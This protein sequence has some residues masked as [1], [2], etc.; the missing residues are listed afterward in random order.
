[1]APRFSLLRIATVAIT[2]SSQSD[3][4][5]VSR[6]LGESRKAACSGYEE[7]WGLCNT[8]K[9]PHECKPSP[10]KWS[11]WSQW[12]GMGMCTGLCS[13]ER[14]IQQVNNDCGTPCEG[15][16]FQTKECGGENVCILPKAVDC[17]YSHWTQWSHCDNMADQSYSER[18]FYQHPKYG[19]NACT[20]DVKRTKPCSKHS[21]TT[22]AAD[23]VLSQWTVWSACSRTCNTGHQVRTRRVVQETMWGGKGCDGSISQTQECGTS[24]C[25]GDIDCKL[26]DWTEWS[27]CESATKTGSFQRYRTR[28]VNQPAV[29]DG[30]PCAGAV[31]GIEECE[32]AKVA[33]KCVFDK[34]QAWGSCSAT[35]GGGQKYRNRHFKT[36]ASGGGS[37]PLTTMQETN[38]C[39]T[40]PC[41]KS[42]KYDDWSKWSECSAKCG[43]GQQTRERKVKDGHECEGAV[44]EVK[45]CISKHGCDVKDCRWGLWEPWSAC[46]LTCGGGT[47][48]RDR[49]VKQS[50]THGG[51]ECKAVP[52]R[53]IAPCNSKS[54]GPDCRDGTWS[55]W[56]SWS[57]CSA[58]CE[59]GFQSRQRLIASAP[60]YCGKPA[61]GL[62]VEMKKCSNNAKCAPS[63]DCELGKWSSWGS[64][65]QDCFGVRERTRRVV[66][67]A[68]GFFGKPCTN[69]SLKD[70]QG[71]NPADGEKTP[72]HC[73]LGP[74]PVDCKMSDWGAWSDCSK[75]CGPGQKTRVRSI[76]TYPESNGKPCNA[77]LKFTTSCQLKACEGPKC[78]DCKWGNWGEWGDC[79][80]QCDG[81]RE[82][83]RSIAVLPDWCGKNCS[84]SPAVETQPCKGVCLA[85]VFC[86]WSGWSTKSS[87]SDK[88]GPQTSSKSRSLKIVPKLP[89][90][91]PLS[92]GTKL[93]TCHG[94]DR[95][96][97]VCPFKSCDG[98][99]ED[100]EF[101]DWDEWSPPTCT[102][103]CE[104]SRTVKKNAKNGGKPCTG[105][106]VATKVCK[107]DCEKPVDC[108]ISGWASWSKC[109]A[110]NDQ[111]YRT[112]SIK[113]IA[114]FGGDRCNGELK[115]TKWCAPTK[116]PVDCE[117]GEWA[118][119]QTCTAS[120]GGGSRK[121]Q[122]SIKTNAIHGGKPCKD[123]LEQL[124]PC[125]AAAA[126]KDKKPKKPVACRLSTWSPWKNDAA[127]GQKKR[128][129]AIKTNRSDGGDMCSGNLHEVEPMDPLD[130]TVSAWAEWD[131][132]DR[133]C[134]NGQQQRKRQVDAHAAW[135]G[136]K[137]PSPLSLLEV[138][139]CSGND[140]S[141]EEQ[142]KGDA[143]V[144][145]W[146][147]WSKCTATCG[148]GQQAR[149]RHVV[150]ERGATGKGFVGMLEQTRSCAQKDSKPC[151]KTDCRWHDWSHWGKCS[152]S[153]DGGQ[154]TRKRDIAEAPKDHGKT[155]LAQSGAEMRSCNTHLCNAPKCVDAEWGTWSKWSACSSSCLGGVQHRHRIV[156]TP[157]NTCGKPT[158]GLDKEYK[159][160]ND[161][162]ACSNAD[163]EFNKWEEWSKCD[164]KC[165]GL[166][167]RDR[168]IKTK[169]STDGKPCVG[170]LQELR[171]CNPAH[172]TKG[173]HVVEKRDCEFD[174]WVS[175]A[176]PVTCGHGEIMKTRAIKVPSTDAGKP[177]SG[178][179]KEVEACKD[180]KPCPK[181]KPVDCKWSSWSTWGACDKCGGQRKRFRAIEKAPAH[182]GKICEAADT[183]QSEGCTG[184]SMCTR[185]YCIWSNWQH[186]SSCSRSCGS[187]KRSRRR[188]LG[189]SHKPASDSAKDEKLFE[190]YQELSIQLD[191]KSTQQWQELLFAFVAGCMS[192][193][194]VVL[195]TRVFRRARHRST[196]NL[197]AGQ[198]EPPRDTYQSLTPQLISSA[199]DSAEG[200]YE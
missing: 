197:Y 26:G 52:K 62:T 183:E 2:V 114:Q 171:T 9:C 71:C 162:V 3:A 111:T 116:K 139:G 21:E 115:Q 92:N 131:D 54:C 98:K 160:C 79:M 141:C 15:D 11:S 193:L 190:T 77:P 63:K 103:L 106:L 153:C 128:E 178:H 136:R 40:D 58:T 20:G 25:V 187:G 177:C 13:R 191:E 104:R 97:E 51:K 120:C 151:A 129:R 70:V 36:P 35:C 135:G 144:S 7:A 1:M 107:K 119:W 158:E 140:K 121:R 192:F 118:S 195:A 34:W 122:R 124:T 137:C 5:G 73:K 31:R 167:R 44:A 8:D 89:H 29:G 156:K 165:D 68:Q 99:P 42:C 125:G 18:A 78:R 108:E 101:G 112:R 143:Q 37:C 55:D 127:T 181:P 174:K 146:A 179:V 90:P 43:S 27:N 175:S 152:K 50:P 100:C 145:Q 161:G 83:H 16:K 194:T 113:Q 96:V 166:Q 159:K 76:T 88:C 163:C 149:S 170:G 200:A 164:A 132:C 94:E 138:R 6:E 75:E 109:T 176:C 61:Q 10:C 130:C 185:T 53:E 80:G 24:K 49:L 105:P 186:W 72:D 28:D 17:Q 148:P 168:T 157:A 110:N 22:G 64:C 82:R 117:I 60:N 180:L 199:E 32:V 173:C 86:T 45:Q 30:K 172:K 56:S 93:Q 46:S 147:E 67:F 59:S 65:L 48:A 188:T 95:K 57:K 12:A 91:A 102:Q 23:C 38:G 87:C 66:S 196:E 84:H 4:G 74:A 155:C 14:T 19:G 189:E 198:A 123:A 47:K 169:G 41:P 133:K 33:Q 142:T 81:Q 184:A 69:S 182:G 39:S 150:K 126:C 85:T 134:E 154:Q